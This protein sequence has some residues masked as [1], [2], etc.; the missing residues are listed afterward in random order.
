MSAL[1]K[2][3]LAAVGLQG[4]PETIPH[5]WFP[6]S[7]PVLRTKTHCFLHR[8]RLVQANHAKSQVGKFI[9][10]GCM[11]LHH[12]RFSS[13]APPEKHKIWSLL[14]RKISV[15]DVLNFNTL[16]LFILGW[17]AGLIFIKINSMNSFKKLYCQQNTY[18]YSNKLHSRVANFMHMCVLVPLSMVELKFENYSCV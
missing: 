8:C 4:T 3:L 5:R 17:R 13:C 16:F 15:W 11:Q 2:P 6:C 7:C 18:W 10:P 1:V 9:L 12:T 14:W